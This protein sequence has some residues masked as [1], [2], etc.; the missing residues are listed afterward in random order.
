[1]A[2]RVFYSWQSDRGQNRNFVR[3]ALRAAIKELRQDLALDEA[4]R[5][6]TLDQDTQGLP[7]SPAIAD[8]ILTVST[9]KNF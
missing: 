6:I 1:M 2:V 5:D 8:A 7:G 4:Q 3:S 9:V